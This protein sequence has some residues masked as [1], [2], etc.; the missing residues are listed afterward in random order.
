MDIIKI[1]PRKYKNPPTLFPVKKQNS[2]KDFKMPQRFFNTKTPLKN[3]K[4]PRKIQ[5][6]QTKTKTYVL[7]GL[8]YI[9]GEKP[10]GRFLIV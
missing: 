2:P 3:T 5:N 9:L 8:L 1:A 10:L 7:W 6:N 4:F